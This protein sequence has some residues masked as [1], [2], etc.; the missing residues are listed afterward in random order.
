VIWYITVIDPQTNT[1]LFAG[2]GRDR[3]E[4]GR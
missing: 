1:V 3:E 4:I 2:N